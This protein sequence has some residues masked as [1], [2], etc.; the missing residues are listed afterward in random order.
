MLKVTGACGETTLDDWFLTPCSVRRTAGQTLME[1]LHLIIYAP[2]KQHVSSYG[3][4]AYRALV[5]RARNTC[6]FEFLAE[7]FI[8]CPLSFPIAVCHWCHGG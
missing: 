7:T 5:I 8:A 6:K 2:T 3:Y 4:V 1:V